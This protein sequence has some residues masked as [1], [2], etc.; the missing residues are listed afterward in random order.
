[1]LVKKIHQNITFIY[2]NSIVIPN[3]LSFYSISKSLALKNIVLAP[4]VGLQKY[5]VLYYFYFLVR[6][7][8]TGGT[9]WGHLRRSEISFSLSNHCCGEFGCLPEPRVPEITFSH[10]FKQIGR[11][12]FCQDEWGFLMFSNISSIP[13]L[14]GPQ[15]AWVHEL[16]QLQILPWTIDHAR[17]IVVCTSTL[18]FMITSFSSFIK[19]IDGGSCMELRSTKCREVPWG[20]SME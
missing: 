8:S 10:R 17:A 13:L 16:K 15:V 9:N 4:Y 7:S 14:I 3:V 19:S 18:P 2:K 6:S 12:E 1:V 20:K 5:F 11:W